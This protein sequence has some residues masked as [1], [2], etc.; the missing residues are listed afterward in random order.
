MSA[1]LDWSYS[2]L[3]ESERVVLRRLA[4]FAG[5][6]TMESASAVLATTGVPAPLAVDAIANLVVK[7]LVSANTERSVA[8]YRLLDTTR[9]Y[10]LFKLE[11]SGE[12]DR[13]AQ[14]HAEHYRQLLEAAQASW[15]T[16][17]ATEW[18]ET[19]RHLLDNARSALN[20]AFTSTGNSSTGVALTIAA[21]PLWFHLSLISECAESIDRAL[22]TPEASR[23]G[24]RDISLHA[25]RRLDFDADEGIGARDAGRFDKGSRTGGT[26]GR[27]D[28]QLRALWGLWAGLLN[29]CELRDALKTA[30]KFSEIA[31]SHSDAQDRLV[32]DRMIGYLLHL[33]G[34]Q[35]RAKRYIERMLG[36]YKSPVIGAEI[37]RYIF[38]QRATAQC[39]L[40]RIVWLQ[41]LPGEAMRQVDTIVAGAVTSKNVL[42]LCQ[43]IVQAA[44]PVSL[45]AGDLK[46]VERYVGMLLDNSVPQSLGFWRVYGRCYR[47]LLFVR[48][49]ELTEGIAMLGAALEELR[50]IQYGV[51]YTMFLS[52]YALALGRAGR[53]EDGQKAIEMALSR[54]ETNE[55]RWYL[56]EA[57]RIRGEV[58][59][60]SGTAEG[61][62]AAERCFR[63]GLELT[64]QQ[65]TPAWQLRTALS[66]ARYWGPRQRADEAH[67]VLAEALRTLRRAWMTLPGRQGALGERRVEINNDLHRPAG[68]SV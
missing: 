31:A 23:G 2:H 64:R 17:P 4:I 22:S 67:G 37:I 54:C 48:R 43:V 36:Q 49:D 50:D 20:W 21:I 52:E 5:G 25:T 18:L 51:Y 8:S 12:R 65:S 14:I 45:Y 40:A 35:I 13:L 16:E 6:F 61:D 58:L 10:S 60:L 41:G 68:Q 44:C 1:T 27:W 62:L 57:L 32:G 66:L 15:K 28:H 30:E 7:S 38:D 46:S 55:E 56:P 3:P 33:L 42:S 9:D 11:E 63:D 19:H 59:L 29:R 34:D 47:A 39:F 53:R 26:G 24:E